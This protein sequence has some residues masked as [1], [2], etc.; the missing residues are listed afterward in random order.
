MPA[1]RIYNIQLL[2]LDTSTTE[3]VG[4]SGYKNLFE[5]LNKVVGTKVEQKTIVQ[6]SFP[7]VNDTYI[8][9]LTINTTQN[10]SYSHGEFVKFHRADKVLD[11]YTNATLY[12]ADNS[13]SAVSSIH[14]FR[15]VF[16]Y[17]THQLAIEDSGSTLPSPLVFL[18]VLQFFLR[19]IAEENFIE[20]I[21]TIN[22]V[23]DEK[24][25]NEILRDADGFS[26]AQVKLT[27][28]NGPVLNDLLQEFKEKN[29]HR[30]DH[31]TSS[32]RGAIMPDITD[33]MKALLEGATRYG[34]AAITY[35]K[36]QKMINGTDLHLK[37]R[38][39][40]KNSH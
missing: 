27:F 39:F 23:S 4:I 38:T 11:F 8:S 5:L 6:Y 15:Y 12:T 2:P 28:P 37:L 20:Y 14:T 26:R 25:L 1:F 22:L 17:E 18:N 19:P 30:V 7:L 3:E 10:K 29:V 36:K 34:E 32:E 35:Y 24:V 31:S 40:L 16:D 33:Y 21:F 13:S 9:P